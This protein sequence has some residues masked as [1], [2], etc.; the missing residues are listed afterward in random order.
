MSAAFLP[1]SPIVRP[2]PRSAE[3]TPRTVIQRNRG[4][5]VLLLRA[6]APARN[7]RRRIAACLP[8]GKPN[9]SPWPPTGLA[10]GFGPE[11]PYGGPG[12]HARTRP[13]DSP[14]G[15][16]SPALC[17][18]QRLGGSADRPWSQQRVNRVGC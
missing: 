8:L 4:D 10:D 2:T 11:K 16:G 13:A 14:R 3:Q 9:S 1:P 17:L 6:L 12:R 15:H 5:A 7:R 18:H